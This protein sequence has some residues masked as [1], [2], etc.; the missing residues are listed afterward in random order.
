MEGRPGLSNY[1][2]TLPFKRFNSLTVIQTVISEQFKQLLKLKLP[3][4]NVKVYLYV[5]SFR[6]FAVF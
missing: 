6:G 2:V 3:R 1:I 4:L 5:I